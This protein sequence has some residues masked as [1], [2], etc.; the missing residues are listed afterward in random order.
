MQLQGGRWGRIDGAPFSPA[1]TSSHTFLSITL[2]SPFALQR[3]KPL[4]KALRSNGF[5]GRDARCRL[6]C[7]SCCRRA[8]GRSK[9]QSCRVTTYG[10]CYEKIG[11]ERLNET[12]SFEGDRREQCSSMPTGP[13]WSTRSKE[14]KEPRCQRVYAPFEAR[15]GNANRPQRPE[16]LEVSISRSLARRRQ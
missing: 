9:R 8:V 13:S 10:S 2:S 15:A 16:S 4:R 7:F 5:R 1:S 3:L 11:P 6:C 14:A 12:V